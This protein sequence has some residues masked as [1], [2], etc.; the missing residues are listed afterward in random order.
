[1]THK[2]FILV[3]QAL[4]TL[5]RRDIEVITETAK[6]HYDGL[7]QSVARPGKESFVWAWNVLCGL[8]K[9][10][11]QVR[12][13]IDVKVSNHEADIVCKI[14]EQTPRL[15]LPDIPHGYRLKGEFQRMMLSMSDECKRANPEA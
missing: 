9:D 5:T 1:M 12:D 13:Q 10:A 15:D 6:R 8:Y 14:L 11:T 2:G 4:I 3:P 7:C